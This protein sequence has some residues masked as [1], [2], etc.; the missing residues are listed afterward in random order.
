MAVK[1][2]VYGTADMRQIERAR[3]ELDKLEQAARGNASGFAGS[4]A[5]LGSS[6][7]SA[8]A[9]MTATG[10]AM[11][12]SL[13]LPIAGAA[14]AI[15]IATKAAADDAQ[16]QV[17]LA[18]N[19]RNTAGAS[20]ASIAATERWI[21]AQGK[22]LGVADDQLRPALA[23]LAGATGDVAK[24]QELASL[25]MDVSAARGV[26]LEAAS[27]AIAK[28][29]DGNFT[30][31]KKLIPGLDEAAI[32]SGDFTQVQA[33]LAGMVGGAATAAADT[34]AGAM[35]RAK[36]AMDEAKET[37]GAAFLPVLQTFADILSNTIAPA[38]QAVGEWFGSLS[39]KT[40]TTIVVI[41]GI[42]AAIGPVLM[43]LGSLTSSVGSLLPLISKIGPAFS[44]MLGPVGIILGLLGALIAASPELREMLGNVLQK[45]IETLA[46]VFQRLVAAIQP[47]IEALG[48]AFMQVVQMLVDSGII[49][50]LADAFMRILEAV[51]PLIDAVFSLV[52]PFLQLVKPIMDLVLTLLQPLIDL[53]GVILP[54]VLDIV[55]AAIE[56]V[57]GWLTYWIDMFSGVL[58]AVGI[59]TKFLNGEFTVQEF[60]SKLISIGG[61]FADII[62]WT[63]D[64][65]NNIK[66][67]VREAV[68]N[69][70]NFARDVGRFIGNAID[71]FVKLPGRIGDAL[72]GAATWLVN[73]G[74]DVV[75]GLLNGI[76]NAW[77]A[78]TK[79]VKNA[80]DGLIGGV[81]DFLG[82]KSPSRVFMTIGEQIGQGLQNGIASMSSSV[83]DAAVG[84]AESATIAATQT[85]G[86]TM[87]G[88]S[89]A[90]MLSPTP[91]YATGSSMTSVRSSSSSVTI[92]PGAVQV[93]FTGETDSVS[94][95]QAI[96]DAFAQLVRE[97]RAS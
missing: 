6:L 30:S 33:A 42:V 75:T 89:S 86:L 25:A 32:A 38:I 51:M 85:I 63:V 15:G 10:Q 28:A 84:L 29:Y 76:K 14:A 41:A 66:Q 39:E 12:T 90:S 20:D 83:R 53:L 47:V 64:V 54:P 21:A 81:K 94:A 9:K 58:E 11:T 16:A 24:A 79:W 91:A 71:W 18:Q 19:L 5:R 49:Q 56:V 70:S 92:A 87:S 59:V 13:T 88:A 67:F 74:R 82:I 1:V 26:D 96:E 72:A 48:G 17:V 52:E 45:T 60:I 50:T 36:V 73:V 62:K 22:A 78:V 68:Q 34:Q 8:G 80:I 35:Q 97:L 27:K 37:I 40:R 95:R 4:M 44:G 61:P 23:L 93:S 31:L 2:T 57:V 43:V 65:T 77:S 69:V 7:E 46:P 55:V 3:G